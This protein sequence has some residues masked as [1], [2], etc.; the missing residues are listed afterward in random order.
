MP[1]AMKAARATALVQELLHSRAPVGHV[2]RNLAELYPRAVFNHGSAVG[3]TVIHPQG[4]RLPKA[5]Q[6]HAGIIIEVRPD[7]VR[8]TKDRDGALEGVGA[9]HVSAVWSHF[10]RCT[11][12]EPDGILG[13]RTK[14]KMRELAV[15]PNGAM[16]KPEPVRKTA[17]EWLLEDD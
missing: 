3:L 6:H 9:A 2:L 4:M 14:A 5:L 11:G 8:V 16:S 12:L 15:I 17:L 7:S 10:Q 1:L 13:P